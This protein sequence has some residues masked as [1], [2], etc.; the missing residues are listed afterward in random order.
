MVKKCSAG[1]WTLEQLKANDHAEPSSPYPATWPEK[2]SSSKS[3]VALIAAIFKTSSAEDPARSVFKTFTEIY[4]WIFAR[5]KSRSRIGKLCAEHDSRWK[6]ER[7]KYHDHIEAGR[8][9]LNEYRVIRC[10]K[11]IANKQWKTFSDIKAVEHF[12]WES[13]GVCAALLTADLNRVSTETCDYS[14]LSAITIKV[15]LT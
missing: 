5:K 11:T 9:L 10:H 4:S 7:S 1:K 8:K 3:E 12:N 6:L 13:C 2:S 15:S 14:F